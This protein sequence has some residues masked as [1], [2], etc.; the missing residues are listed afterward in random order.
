[1]NIVRVHIPSAIHEYPIFIDSCMDRHLE[2]VL[3]KSKHTAFLVISDE[4]VLSIYGDHMHAVLAATGIDYHILSIPAGEK[5]K[6][7]ETLLLILEKSVAVELDRYA[8]IIAWGGGVVGDLAGFAA[9]VY[10]RGISYY[11]IPTTLLAQVD[12]SVGGKVGVNFGGY[13]NLAGAFYQPETVFI[14]PQY[15]LTLGEREYR[16]GLA[17]VLKYAFILDR[18]FGDYLKENYDK[19]LERE[20]CTLKAIITVCCNLKK[21]IV[22][23]DERDTGRRRILNFG[24]TIGH[25]FEYALGPEE[26]FHGEAVA[27]GMVVES[28]ISFSEGRI[29]S[30]SRTLIHDLIEIYGLGRIPD[31]LIVP[32]VIRGIR[33]DKKN[34]ASRIGM[35]Y[36]N[37]MGEAEEGWISQEKL[38][39]YLNNFLT[40]E[41]KR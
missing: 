23:A 32:D 15:L 7:L 14:D 6:N 13:K 33:Q 41:K 20:Q 27:L 39:Q 19:V 24:H 34:Q 18:E 21:K 36:L 17:E 5:V 2:D 28:E 38:M 3:R 9:A 12:S 29:D 37:G 35:V 4:N 16:S 30:S 31:K 10:K 26:I 25:G 11:Q 22:S 8:A 40:S 1:M